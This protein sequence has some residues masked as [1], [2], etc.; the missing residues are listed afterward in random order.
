MTALSEIHG[1]ESP[2]HFSEFQRSIDEAVA[3]GDLTKVPV[4][5]LYASEMF[6]ENWYRAPTGETWRLVSPDF[7]FKG[8][9]E[10][11]QSGS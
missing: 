11:V 4:Q 6:D 8:V 5:S 3:R 1:F 2:E 10:K 9:F 7:P